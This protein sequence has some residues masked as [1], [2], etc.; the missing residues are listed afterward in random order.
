MRRLGKKWVEEPTIEEIRRKNK[1]RLKIKNRQQRL[2]EEHKIDDQK[3]SI[4]DNFQSVSN[5]I[6][7]TIKKVDIISIKTNV[8]NKFN[9]LKNKYQATFKKKPK[10]P[11]TSEEKNI[12]PKS[13]MVTI[14]F[15]GIIWFV[16]ACLFIVGIGGIYITFD[17]LKN[18]P[19]L[20]AADLVAPE[21][22]IIYDINNEPIIELGEYKRENISYE[23]MP[24]ALV[25]AFLAI[26]DSRFFTHFGFDIPR[27]S[28]AIIANLK[29]GS[30]AQGGS[31][32]DMQ[33]IKN[34]Y[35]Q[36]DNGEESTIAEK[37]ISRKV[38]EIFL[39][40]EADHTIRKQDIMA[41][42]LNRI[43]F[44]N[45]I[46]GVQKA[47]QYYFGKDAND[48]NLT[49]SAFLAGI[50]NSP[51]IFN[52]YNDL[53]KDNADNIYV[54]SKIEYLQNGENRRNEVIDMM[55]YHG[56]ISEHEAELAKTVH[57]E[58]ELTGINQ[59]WSNS[60][61]YYQSYIDAVI[62]EAKEVTGKDPALASMKIYTNMDPYMQKLVYDIQN[63][64]TEIKYNRANTQSAIVSMNNQTGEI[65]ALG[66]GRNQEG[67]RQWNRATMSK[68]QPGS[69]VKP[70]FE[71]LLAF[72]ALGWATSHTITDQPIFLYG[73]DHLI[74]NAINEYIGD[75]LIPEAVARSLNTPAIQ[76]LQAVID[77][78]GEQYCVDYL[79]SIGFDVDE[80]SF[81]LQYAIGGNTFTVTPV[82]LAGAHAVIMNEGRYIKPHTI[83]TIEMANG[84]VYKSD[85]EGEQVVSPGSAF[86]V[87]TLL[88]N[89]VYGEWFNY[90]Q[91]LKTGF[92][93]FAKTGT[94][95]WGDID[96][97]YGI[98]A[99]SSKDSW[100]V[101]QT[102]NY[103]N[104]IW[105]GFDHADK[106]T[107]FTS[108]D[109]NLNIKGQI[110]RKLILEEVEHFDYEPTNIEM[111]DDVVKITHVKGVYPYV[112][113]VVGTPVTGYILKD[114]YKLNPV[115][116]IKY[117]T[118]EGRLA[119]MA[120]TIVGDSTVEI[121]WLGVGGVE[122]A[123]M[124]DLTATAYSGKT[125]YAVGR[126]YFPLVS[127]ITPS[128]TYY[129]DVYVDGEFK[130]HIET[131]SPFATI[132]IDNAAGHN[133]SITGTWS[134]D[135]Q[136][137]TVKAK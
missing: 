48:L 57:L 54:N 30:F 38:Q 72:E 75:M 52:P 2:V 46:R 34:S 86:M 137:F 106:G 18:K 119:G 135:N 7:N 116:S 1:T 113:P 82:Q 97:K 25:D 61:S 107:Y 56:Y 77:E 78:K 111:P 117:E 105:L 53:I 37:K 32:F 108:Y 59:K 9:I 16:I 99:G 95:D 115:S 66:G 132:T 103:T 69:T 114:F 122:N 104:C 24:N 94:T 6:N 62:A 109:D 90:M 85:T 130:Q 91:I 129:A 96:P 26:E 60:I 70:I 17:M 87:S 120:G 118:K 36:I 58:D 47:A 83:K 22:T 28:K 12:R 80:D 110:G 51:N 4:S 39:A 100:L 45:N 71:Y 40:I 123:N 102:S 21:S 5:K 50:I 3:P 134:N 84:E 65:V 49:E 76:A 121:R 73:S 8:K 64:N 126:Q 93:V 74:R 136:S 81:D 63:E 112:E 101:C 88:Y 127:F 128:A 55:A 41:L 67:A 92:P 19:D 42:Y 44:G 125:E 23:E 89:N 31:T 33:L 15:A 27:F 14:L 10:E 20:K 11:R 131:S 43:N 68:I 98:P 35:F 133:I 79:K 124:K 13:S 29:S